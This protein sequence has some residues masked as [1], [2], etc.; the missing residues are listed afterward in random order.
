MVVLSH[1]NDYTCISVLLRSS[2][3][4]RPKDGYLPA[5]L[6]D[7]V[8]VRGR[9]SVERYAVTAEDLDRGWLQAGQN[10]NNEY[11]YVPHPVFLRPVRL[12]RPGDGRNL[13]IT[14]IL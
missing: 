7:I 6:G 1:S 9:I 4:I 2:E 8:E 12:V 14:E 11:G 5:Q 13:S 3:V 10:L